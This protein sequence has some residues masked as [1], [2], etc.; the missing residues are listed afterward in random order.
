MST[1][2]GAGKP[3]RRPRGRKTRPAVD[4]P[5][6]DE[7]V[8]L[9]PGAGQGHDETIRSAGAFDEFRNVE[10]VNRELFTRQGLKGVAVG[11]PHDQFSRS[12][13][14]DIGRRAVIEMDVDVVKTL[15]KRRRHRNAEV[16]P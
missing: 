7:C 16:T 12:E 10:R 5:L 13:A 9:C 15:Q 3:I 14:D 11:I 4:G 2:A 6:E 1:G 8:S